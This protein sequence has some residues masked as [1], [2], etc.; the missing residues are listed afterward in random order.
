MDSH[1][2][3]SETVMI[4]SQPRHGVVK[5]RNSRFYKRERFINKYR[6][7]ETGMTEKISNLVKAYHP[8]VWVL[9]SGT[10]FARAASYIIASE[11]TFLASAM[12]MMVKPQK[13]RHEKNT[14]GYAAY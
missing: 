8:L 2:I 10:V 12:G 4:G 3:G 13:S 14:P 5:I 11:K 7:G 1:F 9:V 6:V